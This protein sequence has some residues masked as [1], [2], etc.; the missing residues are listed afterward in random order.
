MSR[1]GTASAR[2]LPLGA[3]RDS[4]VGPVVRSPNS[5]GSCR[6]WAPWRH[7]HLHEQLRPI[8]RHLGGEKAERRAE[9]GSRHGV[10]TFLACSDECA[11]EPVVMPVSTGLAA[12]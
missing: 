7:E 9:P 12:A 2:P 3:E 10:P 6:E 4:D 11:C 5:T 8:G 1:S